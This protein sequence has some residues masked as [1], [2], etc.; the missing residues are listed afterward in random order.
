MNINIR[1]ATP[2]DNT[3]LRALMKELVA[4]MNEDFVEKRFEWGIQRRLYDPLQ[5]HG[6]FI[7]E[8]MDADIRPVGMIFAEL[9]VDPFGRSEGYIKQLVV[10]EDYRGQGVGE[11]LLREA[12][13]HLK[14]IRVEKVM[15]N[16]KANVAQ[17]AE[18]L[19]KK[20]DFK[21]KY[22]VMELVFDL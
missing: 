20:F 13:D 9:R 12:I 4:T 22:S 3:A 6:I 21:E 2:E 15:I 11:M 8:D 14:K 16:V 7:A 1:V 18:I 5:K 10:T 17:G 19:Y